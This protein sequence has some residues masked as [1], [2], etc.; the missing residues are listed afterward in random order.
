MKA[1]FVI[2]AKYNSLDAGFMILS[3]HFF[4][5]AGGQGC[6]ATFMS[7]GSIRCVIQDAL[8]HDWDAT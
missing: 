5:P 8:G 7:R 1:H 6:T 3:V 2:P 4:E